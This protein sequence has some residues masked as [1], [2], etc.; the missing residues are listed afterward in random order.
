MVKKRGQKWPLLGSILDPLLNTIW[1]LSGPYLDPHFWTPFVTPTFQK[2]LRNP[3][4]NDPKWSKKGYKKGSKMGS[5]RVKNGS[6]LG[7]F[8]TPNSQKDPRNPPGIGQKWSKMTP[9]IDPHMGVKMTPFLTTFWHL[10]VDF[11]H[12][13]KRE[14]KKGGLK[15]WPK[16][17][18]FVP[19]K[20]AF[21][22][23]NPRRFGP[24]ISVFFK[25]VTFLTFWDPK[26]TKSRPQ[27]YRPGTTRIYR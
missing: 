18:I 1:T 25:K 5:K 17:A 11:R 12:T 13:F 14:L 6:F 16:L 20:I 23:R 3:P 8:L 21:W 24:Q 4:G 19:L 7:S 27:F 9:K 22:A 26:S 15:K 10:F 2:L